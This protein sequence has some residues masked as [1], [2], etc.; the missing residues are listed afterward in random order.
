MVVLGAARSPSYR[1]SM[2]AD[3]DQYVAHL[4]RPVSSQGSFGT[5]RMGEWFIGARNPFGLAVLRKVV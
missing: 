1:K 2:A 3:P 4:G 5:H